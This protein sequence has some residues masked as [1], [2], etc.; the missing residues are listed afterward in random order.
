MV[1]MPSMQAMSK[2]N[3]HTLEQRINAPTGDFE[4]TTFSLKWIVEYSGTLSNILEDMEGSHLGI[5]AVHAREELVER[6][7]P[8]VVFH[9]LRAIIFVNP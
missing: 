1:S 6:L 2:E 9:H 4:Q 8:L 5:D 3:V 7:F